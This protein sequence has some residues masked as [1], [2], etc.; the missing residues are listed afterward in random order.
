[1]LGRAA[2]LKA[3]AEAARKEANSWQQK[4][5]KFGGGEDDALNSTAKTLDAEAATL[6]AAAKYLMDKADAEIASPP[7]AITA[8]DAESLSKTMDNIAA[9]GG[10]AEDQFRALRK[11]LLDSG[12]A[13]KSLA[14]DFDPKEFAVTTANPV[15]DALVG[16]GK[17]TEGLEG[18]AVTQQANQAAIDA[19]PQALLVRLGGIEGLEKLLEERGKTMESLKDLTEEEAVEIATM[20]ADAAGV[21]W[22]V[23]DETDRYA[24]AIDRVRVVLQDQAKGV[25]MVVG[26]TK[27]S[28]VDLTSALNDVLAKSEAAIADLP[29]SDFRG[30]ARLARAALKTL[31]QTIKARGGEGADETAGPALA[32]ARALIA[33]REFDEFE[34]LRRAAQRNAKGRAEKS[35]VGHRFLRSELRSAVDNANQDL[36]VKIIGQAGAAGR[37]IADGMLREAIKAAQEAQRQRRALLKLQA[38][39]ASLFKA[40]TFGWAKDLKFDSVPKAPNPKNTRTCSTRSTTRSL[41]VAGKRTSTRPRLTSPDSRPPAR[42]TRRRRPRTRRPTVR[43]SV[44]RC[45]SCEPTSTC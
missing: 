30:R 31:E 36:L 43:P 20:I 1:M 34:N 35:R 17:G 44:S 29:E 45:W 25:G 32:R 41:R 14:D 27:L 42:A 38:R 22:M 39:A 6:E 5:M 19:T 12:Y 16:Q 13:A 33:Q 28:D 21:D 2:D 3:Q 10:T 4:I 8:F 37:N 9:S 7:T 24:A 26:L 11:A 23:G 15:F 40:I 18:L